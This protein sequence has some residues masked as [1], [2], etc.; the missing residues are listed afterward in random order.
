MILSLSFNGLVG[1]REYNL[2]VRRFLLSFPLLLAGLGAAAE[3]PSATAVVLGAVENIYERPDETSAVDNQAIL[4]ESLE[5][6]RQTAGFAQVRTKSGAVGWIPERA[7]RRRGDHEAR[8]DEND[9][10][11]TIH[12]PLAHVYVAPSFTSARPLLTAPIGAQ[13]AVDREFS[14]GGHAWLA[15]RL[16]GGRAGYVAAPDVEP[17]GADPAPPLK[18][19]ADWIALGQRFLGAPYTWGGTTPLGFDCSGLV[20]RIFERHGVVLK[21]NSSEMCFREPRLVPVSFA[22]LQPGD[23]LFFGTEDKIDHMGMWMGHGKLLQATAHGV[24]STQV[25]EFA[26]SERLKDR[27][28]YAR[29]L[30]DLPGAPK[31]GAIS[32]VNLAALDKTLKSLVAEGGAQYGIVFKDLA[33]GATLRLG[34]DKTMHAASTMKTPVLLEIL[35]RVDD[36]SLK[37][38]DELLVANEFKSVVD[39]SPFALTLDPESD[40]PTM[41]KLGQKATLEFLAREMIVRSSNL[42]TNIVLSHVVPESV[43]R[44]S[45][46]LG[47]PTVKVRRCLEDARAYEKGLNNETDAAGMATIMEAALRSPKLSREAHARAWEILTGQA[48]NEQIPAGLHRQSG[49][50]VAHKTG[51]ISS[52]QHDAAIVRL[53]D[54]REYVLV[55]LAN[56]FGANDAGR[57]RV[58]EQTQKMSRAVWEAMIAPE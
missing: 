23:L 49:A 53:P 15:V 33:S 51:S 4:G 40:G 34:A 29:R 35:R 20:Y 55:I 30:A 21:R 27:F 52:V 11:A 2:D 10:V 31:P 42:A 56:D 41:A 12:S 9:R 26:G 54:G 43:Q 57:K 44:F 48:F 1:R 24:P 28:R 18:S 5:V 47:A 6:V 45:D 7:I 39:G 58:I 8:R 25:S 17:P 22:K 32:Q 46:A 13:L 50:I 3:A 38:S 19:P 37:L 36:G 14:E 16:P